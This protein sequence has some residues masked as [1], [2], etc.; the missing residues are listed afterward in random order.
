LILV[1]HYSNCSFNPWFTTF[2]CSDKIIIHWISCAWIKPKKCYLNYLFTCL[3]FVLHL[4]TFSYTYSVNI[5]KLDR[6]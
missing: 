2:L 6:K 3:F 1:S 5:L 4:K